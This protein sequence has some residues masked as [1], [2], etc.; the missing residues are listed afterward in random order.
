MQ[1]AGPAVSPWTAAADR[2]S[3][4]HRVDRILHNIKGQAGS[5]GYGLITELA[6]LGQALTRKI[7]GNARMVFQHHDQAHR[8]VTALVLAMRLVLQNEIRGDGGDVGARLLD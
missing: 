4:W 3:A 8:C 1:E 6:A 5:F 2:A 7:G